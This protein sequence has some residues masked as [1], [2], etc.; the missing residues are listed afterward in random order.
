M[1]IWYLR[2][3]RIFKILIFT[4]EILSDYGWGGVKYIFIIRK[5]ETN[6]QEKQAFH[7]NCRTI[8]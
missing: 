6:W 4:T 8:Y 2:I 1:S 3:V 5:R 7:D